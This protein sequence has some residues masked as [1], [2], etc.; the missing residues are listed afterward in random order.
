RARTRALGAR[1]VVNDRLDLAL[2]LGA[3]GVH[4]GRLSV[5]IPDARALL[6]AQRARAW[7]SVACH[8]V[9]EVA[10][11]ARDGADAALLSPIFASPG[12]GARARL[13]ARRGAGAGWGGAGHGAAGGV[14]AENA[15]DCFAAGAEGL[16]GIRADLSGFL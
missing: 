16:A 10:R 2:A 7:I 11:A 3:D 1:L 14:S 9:D 4:L 15:R 8:T 5:T 13:G 12:G 6:R